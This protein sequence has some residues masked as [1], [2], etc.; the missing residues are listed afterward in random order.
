MFQNFTKFMLEMTSLFSLNFGALNIA[1][2]FHAI[3]KWF[4]YLYFELFVTFIN[5]EN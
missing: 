2:N 4:G 5:F 1:P 3:L